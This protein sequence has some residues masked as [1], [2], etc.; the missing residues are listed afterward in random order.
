MHTALVFV[1]LLGLAGAVE[2]C[3]LEQTIA[4]HSQSSQQRFDPP[5]LRLDN[6]DSTTT[7]LSA[8]PGLTTP[9]SQPLDDRGGGLLTSTAQT[10]DKRTCTGSRS[11][12][13]LLTG[14][15]FLSP[16]PW[17][18]LEQGIATRHAVRHPQR[19]LSD[20]NQTPTSLA[21]YAPP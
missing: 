13:L 14:L 3:C 17:Y 21:H 15:L 6:F 2:T 4:A 7:S 19:L 8:T 16:T 18:D 11:S 20:C 5:T 10:W 9:Q 1:V 12:A